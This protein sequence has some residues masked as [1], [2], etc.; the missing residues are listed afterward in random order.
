MITLLGFALGQIK[1]PLCSD[2][3][4]V[5]QAQG[6]CVESD[7]S[8]GRDGMQNL[9]MTPHSPSVD[10]VNFF[11]YSALYGAAWGFVPQ[12]VVRATIVPRTDIQTLRNVYDNFDTSV[13]DT[14]LPCCAW[15]RT[16]TKSLF[17]KILHARTRALFTI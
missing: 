13:E 15:K 17:G 1:V 8:I 3:K 2:L 12:K 5:Y 11:P 4:T 7:K 9:I 16:L 10:L 14:S 6:C